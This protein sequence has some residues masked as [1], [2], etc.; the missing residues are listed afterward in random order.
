MKLTVERLSTA[1]LAMFLVSVFFPAPAYAESIPFDSP[2]WVIP[3]GAAHVEEYLGKKSLFLFGGIAYLK[4]VDFT[5]GIIEFDVAFP[6]KRGFHGG[7]FRMQDNANFEEFYL[8]SH[9]SGN[10]D[11]LQYT[12]VFNGMAAWQLY[13]GKGFGGAVNFQFDKW[14][15]IKLIVSGN[16]AELYIDNNDQ[17]VLYMSDLKRE[18]KPG[19]IG[20]KALRFS[21]GHF[22]DFSVTQMDNPALK[23]KK[24]P[25]EEMAA[26]TVTA[27]S[28]SGAFPENALGKKLL[29]TDA[30]KT[31]LEWKKLQ[32]ESSGLANISRVVK[33]E[34]PKNTVFAK[35][36]IDSDKQRE[37]ILRFG[38]SDRVRVF[39]NGRLLYMGMNNYRSRDYRFLG[40]IGYFDALALPLEKGRNE[41]WLAVS[42]NFGGWG[43]KCRFEDSKGIKIN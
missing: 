5:D 33:L 25:P 41:L 23:N 31:N 35:I 36:E 42:E 24:T 8:R 26:G 40:T 4:D 34:R 1:V 11:A 43:I 9:Q 17:P 3:T 30:D 7:V 12:P 6:G 14:M 20:V 21:P 2:R 18:L 37:K 29:L 39:L 10:P 16:T 32:S 19:K 38:Y 22:A 27:W 13:H 28:I 15:H